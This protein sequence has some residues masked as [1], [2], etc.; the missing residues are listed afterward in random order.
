[1]HDTSGDE[2]K[3]GIIGSGNVGGAL[4][5]I[6]GRGDHEIM[7]SSRHPENLKGLAESIGKNVFY[8]AAD[9][10][11]RFGDVVV[12]AVPWTQADSA[13][14]SAGPFSGK[15]LIDCTNP[16]KPDMSGLAVGNTTSAAEEVAKMA[17]DARV[18]KAFNTTFAALM[19][20]QSRMF[21]SMRPTGFYCGDDD[22][23]KSVVS[24]LIKETGLDPLDVGPLMSARYLEPLAMLVIQLGFVK[25]MGTNIAMALLKR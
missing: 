6:W 4:G 8:G 7:F 17:K 13:L 19:S 9:E 5:K 25:G 3:I 1:M 22:S 11:V 2:M 10:A 20:S 12:L 18:V 14:K 24:D 21:G 16:L 23:A 15:I